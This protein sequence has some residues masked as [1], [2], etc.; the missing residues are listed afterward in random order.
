[1]QY[2]YQEYQFGYVSSWMQCLCSDPFFILHLTA[3]ITH[4]ILIGAFQSGAKSQVI[5]KFINKYE[6]A[7][8]Y[9]FISLHHNKHRSEYNVNIIQC[10]Y[11]WRTMTALATHSNW[12]QIQLRNVHYVQY[13]TGTLHEQA[14]AYA[15]RPLTNR[16]AVRNVGN[17]QAVANLASLT[18]RRQPF[19]CA[20]RPL[21]N[22][23]T[24]RRL[25]D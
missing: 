24:F 18:K 17:L 19:A 5:A 14:L 1:M 6:L 11:Q 22:P 23:R 2:S 21:T 9:L 4:Q 25:G 8:E 12:K 16:S 3:N 20:C 10:N 13:L 15:C 7:H